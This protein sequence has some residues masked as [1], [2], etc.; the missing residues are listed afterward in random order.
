MIVSAFSIT[1]K[2]QSATM[3][4][5][6]RTRARGPT[7]HTTLSPPPPPRLRRQVL[8]DSLLT[9]VEFLNQRQA[10]QVDDGF[11]AD[12]LALDWLEWNGGT[13][14]LTVTGTNVCEQLRAGL[15]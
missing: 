15:E 9:T 12:Y 8:R 6:T 2:Q 1:L 4:R 11:I 3:S 13:L 10:D 7:D 5:L 14:R